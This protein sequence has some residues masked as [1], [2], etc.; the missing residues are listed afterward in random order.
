MDASGSRR[1]TFVYGLLV[2]IRITCN[3]CTRVERFYTIYYGR[4]M[5]AR[6]YIF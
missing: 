2:C 6:V 3:K 5:H 4:T 1:T